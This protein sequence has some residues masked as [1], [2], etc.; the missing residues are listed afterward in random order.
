M[1]DTPPPSPAARPRPQSDS[2]R[3]LATRGLL[4]ASLLV[5]PSLVLPSVVHGVGKQPKKTDGLYAVFVN[6][7]CTG[8]G[9]AT[10]LKKVIA[11]VA[12][13]EDA[14]GVKG[15]VVATLVLDGDHFRGVGTVI[16]RPAT[17]FG[18]LDGYDGDKH[19]RGARLLCN[20]TD[21]RGHS[22][23]VVGTFP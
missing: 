8:R 7:S 17:F 6:G 18:R 16:D 15:L 22:G 5:L 21:A 10:V 23:R 2:R 12:T 9:T 13:A 14:R 4:A 3:R 19:F 11:V 20:Y 1:G